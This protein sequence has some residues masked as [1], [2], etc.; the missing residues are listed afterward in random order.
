M[1]AFGA[2][3]RA[4]RASFTGRAWVETRSG[5]SATQ[6]AS[7][8]RPSRDARG[9]KQ[10]DHVLAYR[11]KG[12][13]RPS[14]DARGLKPLGLVAAPLTMGRADITGRAWVETWYVR[15][16]L[17]MAR[18]RASFTGRAWVETCLAS[19]RCLTA[20]VARPSRDARGLKHVR[21]ANRGRRV[22]S[23][24][25]FTGRAWVETETSSS[26]TR[27]AVVARPSRDARGL[28]HDGARIAILST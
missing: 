2:E 21:Q 14:R 5:L 16:I 20:S 23:R 25:S 19:R 15:S 24:A 6:T 18:S 27:T 11:R 28:K 1:M 13:A 17:T 12:V 26:Q 9:L 3:N 8:A 22:G 10:S 7:V 4:S